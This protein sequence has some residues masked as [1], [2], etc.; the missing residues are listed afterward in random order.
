L[1]FPY[2]KLNALANN[3]NGEG[4][5]AGSA[6]DLVGLEEE[7]RGDREAQGLGEVFPDKA[8]NF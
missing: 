6:D 8:S 5:T 1:A 4:V 3:I 2:F 7:G